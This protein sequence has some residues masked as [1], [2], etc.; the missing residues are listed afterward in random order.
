LYKKSSGTDGRPVIA[1][2]PGV[3]G[4]YDQP[5]FLFWSMQ[6]HCSTRKHGTST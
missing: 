5:L 1:K 3:T 4:S 2:Q 6:L